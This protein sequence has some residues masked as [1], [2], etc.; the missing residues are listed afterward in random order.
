MPSQHLVMK[1]P[2]PL[3]MTLSSAFPPVMMN[4]MTQRYPTVRHWTPTTSS[5][6]RIYSQHLHQ[7]GDLAQMPQG[8]A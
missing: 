2:A 1:D 6:F 4:H 5:R 7:L 8:I 3:P